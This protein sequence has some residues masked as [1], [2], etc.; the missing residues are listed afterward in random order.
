MSETQK[1]LPS[2]GNEDLKWVELVVQ[3]VGSLRYGGVEIVV[4]DSRV[5][6]IERTE[7]LRLDKSPD[8]QRPGRTK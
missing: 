4:H 1:T 2:G 5:V 3:Q 7:R 6:Q 8:D